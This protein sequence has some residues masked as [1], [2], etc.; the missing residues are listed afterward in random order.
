[1]E[2]LLDFREIMGNKEQN[3][4]KVGEKEYLEETLGF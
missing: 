4:G 1:M 3:T 2:N